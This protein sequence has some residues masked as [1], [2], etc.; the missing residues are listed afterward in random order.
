MAAVIALGVGLWLGW[1]TY[2]RL[3][4]NMAPFGVD[5]TYPWRA[6][7]HVA[8]GETPIKNMPRALRVGR[9]VSPPAPI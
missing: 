1:W 6:A 5:F 2:D 9:V 8:A 3:A 7:G 4:A